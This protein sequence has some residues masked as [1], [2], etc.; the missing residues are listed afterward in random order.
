MLFLKNVPLQNLTT[1]K[2]GGRVS[3]Y[4]EP[5]DLKEISLCIDF[6]KSR[7]IPLFV[8]GNG[9]NTI[10]GD[11]RGLVVN[12]KNL[13]GFKVKEI[14][15]KFFVEAFSGTPLKDLIRFSVK[16][17]VKSFYK[18]LGF[19]AS[20]G[21]AVSMNAGAFGVEI[22][23]FLKEVYFVD[24]EGKLQ[25]AKRDELNFSYRK[26]PFPKLGIVFKV[27]FE[28]ERSKENIL[29]KYEKIRRIRKEKQ[30]INL[31]T[32]GSTF[33]NPEGN[34]AGKLLEKAGLKGFRLKNVGFSEKHANFLVN[35]GGGTF[36]EVV[37]LINIAKERVYENFGIVLEEEVKLIESSGSDGWKVL[38]A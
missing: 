11:V 12:L 20:V 17:N 21:G 19:P 9:S 18:L 28:F 1:I 23:D 33:K 24:W 26:S 14:K 25:K 2:I 6:S 30:P 32:S 34:F 31:P 38:G 29:P 27:V 5:S 10:F 4:A 22:S 37:D 7:D 35:Y 8:L 3:F 13:K 36:S 16:E 15:G